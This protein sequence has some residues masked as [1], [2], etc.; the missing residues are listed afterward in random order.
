MHPL[1][2]PTKG[3]LEFIFDRIDDHDVLCCKAFEY[4]QEYGI[5][6]EKH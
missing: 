3:Y 2:E 6:A 5:Q 1:L 4:E